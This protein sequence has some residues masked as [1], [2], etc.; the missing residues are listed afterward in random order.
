MS[1]RDV[2]KRKMVKRI[3]TTWGV[4]GYESCMQC[5]LSFMRGIV[6]QRMMVGGDMQSSDREIETSKCFLHC[7]YVWSEGQWEERNVLSVLHQ[8]PGGHP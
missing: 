4:D 2:D 3:K 1:R 6:W 7:T 5:P 8:N